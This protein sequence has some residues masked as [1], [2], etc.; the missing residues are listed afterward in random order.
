MVILE[1]HFPGIS[2]AIYTV[3]GHLAGIDV[4]AGESVE[5]GQVIGTVG[6]TGAATG[7]HL[8]FEARVGSDRQA[9]TQ[10]PE[11][12]LV[13]SEHGLRGL[14]SAIA[15][16]IQKA[17]GSLVSIKNIAVQAIDDQTGLLTKPVYYLESYADTSF[18]PDTVWRE[19]FA[20]GDLPRALYRVAFQYEGRQ[21]MVS[22]PAEAGKLS[23]MVIT[24]P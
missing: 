3:Y 16:R 21:V 22:V 5:S 17:D 1:H 12:W 11:L 8:H 23:V 9:D 19:N 14:G 2:E 24:V 6:A 7:P 20:I 18:H 10:N 4:E 13:P 15:G